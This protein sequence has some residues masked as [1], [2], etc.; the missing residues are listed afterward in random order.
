VGHGRIPVNVQYR[1]LAMADIEAVVDVLSLSPTL[2]TS[3]IVA[4]DPVS[5][6]TLA[7]FIAQD[8][9]TTSVQVHQAV[10][11]PVVFRHKW[12]EEIASYIFTQAGRLKMYG[13]VP[14]NNENAISVNLKIGFKEMV[15]LEDAYDVGVDYVLMELKREDCPYWKPVNEMAA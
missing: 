6:E 14:S 8:W 15:R 1:Q 7:V 3:G 12:L 2:D 4:Y 10:H 13:L 9:T 11:N 5:H